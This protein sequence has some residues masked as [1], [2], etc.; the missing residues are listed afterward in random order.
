MQVHSK[1]VILVMAAAMAEDMRR[2]RHDSALGD[3]VSLPT[4][5]RD[6]SERLG[7]RKS[8]SFGAGLNLPTASIKEQY[9]RLPVAPQ[10]SRPHD[11]TDVPASAGKDTGGSS[12]SAVATVPAEAGSG[13][14]PPQQE[15][16]TLRGLQISQEWLA[17]GDPHDWGRPQPA[18]NR[19]MS[20]EDL[21]SSSLGDVAAAADER[22]FSRRSA[23]SPPGKGLRISQATQEWLDSA[24]LS[25]DWGRPQAGGGRLSCEDLGCVALSA[26]AAAE[27]E[28][29]ENSS[30]LPLVSVQEA[31]A[32][33]T[34]SEQ[35]LDRLLNRAVD[36]TYGE[37]GE[38]DRGG[39]RGK[40]RMS[41][42][43]ISFGGAK[44]TRRGFMDPTPLT[45]RGSTSDPVHSNAQPQVQAPRNARRCTIGGRRTSLDTSAGPLSGPLP[46]GADNRCPRCR[47]SSVVSGDI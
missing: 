14:P 22:R 3:R 38:S 11:P 34:D 37:V 20:C 46:E 36:A 47:K 17:S 7:R 31:A 25:E 1:M 45:R 40:Y 18:A 8:A 9:S 43:S 28:R 2:Q 35:S 39:K 21:G 16:G 33:P 42:P 24:D 4:A 44:P 10:G 19:T 13:R 30:T 6:T 15:A 27:D 26:A 5:S 23:S 12:L 32:A 41:L 29:L